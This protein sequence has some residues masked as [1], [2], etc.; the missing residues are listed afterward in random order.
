MNVNI[1]FGN[2]NIGQK[3]LNNN[4]HTGILRPFIN[5]DGVSYYTNAKGVVQPIAN[6]SLRKEEW[7][8]FDE[9]ILKVAQERLVGYDSLV[10][11]GLT[12]DL[13]SGMAK[14]IL[15]S[16]DVS[17]FTPAEI[18]MNGLKRSNADQPDY[19]SV[20]LPL[21]IIHKDFGIDAR[22]LA[23]SRTLG[24]PLDVTSA[25][26]ASRTIS[27]MKE[28][29]LFGSET[30]TFAGATIHTFRT[31]PHRNILSASYGWLH[32]SATGE[33]I[34]ENV[35]R[36][37]QS[38]IDNQQFGPYVLYIPG[39][40][41]TVLD[42]DYVVGTKATGK[43]IRQRL[44]EIGGLEDIKVVDML[45]SEELIMVNMRSDTI[46]LVR[47]M[48]NT[49]VEWQEEGGMAL[50]FKV[51]SIEVPQIRS[52]YKKQCGVSHMTFLAT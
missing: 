6:A 34:F 23:N 10:S 47:A 35:R 30:F 11:R 20:N 15:Q 41:D 14:N 32:T 16:E 42:K 50:K 7:L 52:T 18:S 1:G 49:M 8:A 27:E 4:M 28:N 38:L 44:M 29:L 21:P 36:L 31:Y 12:Y 2:S 22:S 51:L 5:D 43:T 37:K 39:A 46:R 3:L 33:T 45:T 24:D 48:P 25:E 17:D 13:N 40:Y 19:G 26:L 9:A